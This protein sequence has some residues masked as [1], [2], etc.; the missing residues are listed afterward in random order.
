MLI[1]QRRRD[2]EPVAVIDCK[3]FLGNFWNNKYGVCIFDPDGVYPNRDTIKRTEKC[4][5]V[6]DEIRC[7]VVDMGDIEEG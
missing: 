3:E 2:G 4:P 5:S 7:H 1:E 6:S